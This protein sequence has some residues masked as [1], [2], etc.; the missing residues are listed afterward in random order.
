M[1]DGTEVESFKLGELAVW[2]LV[3]ILEEI[4]A[5]G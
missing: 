5:Y 2:E 4:L 3:Y 1:M